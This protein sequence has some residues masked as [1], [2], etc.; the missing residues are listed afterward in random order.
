MGWD[1]ASDRVMQEVRKRVDYGRY[2]LGMAA[3]GDWRPAAAL[4]GEFFFS[5]DDVPSRLQLLRKHLP[6][7]VEQILQR[8]DQICDHRFSLLGYQPLFYGR[9]IDWHLDA[10]H[11]KQAP[12]SAWYQVPFLDFSQVGDHKV[13]WE[14]NRHQHLVVLAKAW[15]L[16]R[17]SKYLAELLAQWEDWQRANPYPMGINWASSLE[18][19]F[20]SVSWLWVWQLLHGSAEMP[21]SW[22]DDL[23]RGLRLHG[24]HIEHYLSTYFSPN[25]H[26]LGEGFALFLLGTLYRMLPEAKRWQARGWKILLDGAE[27]QVRPDGVYFEQALYYHVYALD[28]FL[29]ARRLAEKNGMPVPY[30]F[31]A[32]VRRMLELVRCLSQ[33]GPPQSF[34]DDDGGRAF[35]PARNRRE[36]MADPLA[37]G[38]VVFGGEFRAAPAELT[39]ESVWLYGERAVTCL[40]VSR[41]EI[42]IHS[43]AFEAGGIYVLADPDTSAQ[44]VL[45]AGPQGTGRCGHGHADALSLQFSQAGRSVLVDP[46]TYVYVDGEGARSRFR[47][48]SAHNTLWVDRLDQAKP[49]GPFAWSDIPKVHCERWISGETFDFW[50]ASHDG[51]MGLADPVTHRRFVFRVGGGTW[52]VR[53]VASGTTAH[54]LDLAWHFAP[55]V[56]LSEIE[57]GVL[58]SFGANQKSAVDTQPG[59]A[60]L[61]AAPADWK[62]EIIQEAVSPAYGALESA[63]VARFRAHVALPTE[64]AVRLVPVPYASTDRAV[65]FETGNVTVSAYVCDVSGQA[66]WFLFRIA[67]TWDWN[68]WRSDAEFAYFQIK[69]GRLAHLIGVGGAFVAWHDL[70]VVQHRQSVSHF[71]WT[72]RGGEIEVC[73]SNRR[74]LEQVRREPFESLVSAR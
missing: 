69:G 44:M 7:E 32:V 51:Y 30:E 65:F 70:P 47:G 34:G 26:L 24:L 46:G 10:V 41:E 19:A 36:H 5:T 71:S 1:E 40:A 21:K 49:G 12:L 53:D 63:P 62:K 42:P 55:G 23:A 57:R 16:S 31:D 17:D 45:D 27:R 9:N 48:T 18:V 50:Q 64:C 20:R 66:E 59:L 74:I 15:L 4:P 73:S 3:G 43:T 67:G 11:G 56:Q 52:L 33:A 37:L 35:D 13:I 58:A 28:F 14:L 39:E 60:F 29:H 22:A 68:G 2:R 8:G 72:D 38:A 6:G 54:D 25:T 61:W